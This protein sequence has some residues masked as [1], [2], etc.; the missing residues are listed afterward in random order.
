MDRAT[1]LQM[2]VNGDGQVS[3]AEFLAMVLVQVGKVAQAD[4]DECRRRFD[5]VDKD[6]SGTID[7]TDVA[8]VRK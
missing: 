5:E 6:G 1:T 4:V 7:T 8:L 3:R 2:D